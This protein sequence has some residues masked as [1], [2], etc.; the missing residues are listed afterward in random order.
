M[1]KQL[2]VGTS[3]TTTDAHAAAFE[4]SVVVVEYF[5]DAQRRQQIDHE[6]I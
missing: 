5:E 2:N 1:R 3:W 6:A 4:I